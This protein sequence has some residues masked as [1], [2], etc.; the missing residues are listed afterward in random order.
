MSATSSPGPTLHRLWR[1]LA[2][3]PGGRW[4]FS[5]VFDWMVP[6]TGSIRPRIVHLEPGHARLELRDRRGVRNHL[7]SIHAVALT[8]LAEA[9]SGLAMVG[10][11]PATVRG[12]LV[13]LEIT[14]MKKARGTLVAECVCQVPEVTESQEEAVTVDVRDASGETVARLTARWLLGPVPK[15]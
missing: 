2:P 3:L 14:F 4:L 10:G 8:N 7:N 5:R 12:I 9:T 1:R 15:A 6:Y 11:L 13:A